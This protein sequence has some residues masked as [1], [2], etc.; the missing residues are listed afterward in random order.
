MNRLALSLHNALIPLELLTM[1]LLMVERFHVHN[2][3]QSENFSVSGCLF[4]SEQH[5]ILHI[6][7]D[8]LIVCYLTPT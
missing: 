2:L 5:S 6:T 3:E 1:T 7:V 8:L 4:S